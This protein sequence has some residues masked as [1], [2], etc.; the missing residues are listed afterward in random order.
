MN[1]HTVNY[2]HYKESKR[3]IITIPRAILEAN[4]FNWKHKDDIGIIIKTIDGKQGLFLWKRE[5]KRSKK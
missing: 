3:S 1:G 5:E 2:L 4:N